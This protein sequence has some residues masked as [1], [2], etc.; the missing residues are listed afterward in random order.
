MS[1]GTPATTAITDT[2]VDLSI[3]STIVT[4]N[5]ASF[6]F[7]GLCESYSCLY[8]PCTFGYCACYFDDIYAG[9]LCIPS[10]YATYVGGDY[11][12][13][14]G[15]TFYSTAPYIDGI[16]YDFVLGYPTQYED[17]I[18]FNRTSGILHS[19]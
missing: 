8:G 5:G 17:D 2:T 13:Y 14:E 18:Q 10:N 15:E 7:T 4:N 6:I 12:I 9:T 19:R 16:L 11:H 3:N 1:C